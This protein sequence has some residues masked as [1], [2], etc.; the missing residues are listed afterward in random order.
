MLQIKMFENVSARGLWVAFAQLQDKRYR[1]PRRWSKAFT[2]L[3]ECFATF[4]G[5][6]RG[7]RK[8]Q[9]S[10]PQGLNPSSHLDT[11][12]PQSW[13]RESPGCVPTGHGVDVSSAA[14]GWT[15]SKLLGQPTTETQEPPRTSSTWGRVSNSPQSISCPSLQPQ[16][17]QQLSHRPNPALTQT[18]NGKLLEVHEY[19]LFMGHWLDQLIHYW[20]LSSYSIKS[21]AP[22]KIP[23]SVD[24][25]H[26]WSKV[27]IK[28]EVISGQCTLSS[29][30]EVSYIS[31]F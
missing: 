23:P 9:G 3:P 2:F 11:K 1:A 7:H 27:F 20:G 18:Q 4:P 6:L 31:I 15:S 19:S 30:L 12:A 22:L 16:L 21:L 29:F 17:V 10:T 28:F 26:V 8:H 25:A 13:I 5:G 24:R 14:R